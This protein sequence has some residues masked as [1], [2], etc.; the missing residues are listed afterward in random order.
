M[1]RCPHT[2]FSTELRGGT[3]LVRARLQDLLTAPRR[4]GTL[5]ALLTLLCVATLGSMVACGPDAPAPGPKEPA[6][7]AEVIPTSVSDYVRDRAGEDGVYQFLSSAGSYDHILK[8]GTLELYQAQLGTRDFDPDTTTLAGGMSID[9]NG[10]LFD[11]WTTLFLFQHVEE[12]YV[13]LATAKSSSAGPSSRRPTP[14]SPPSSPPPPPKE[15][16]GWTTAG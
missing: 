4:R 5:P 15:S 9:E 3:R 14:P 12:D 7:T 6:A 2:W 11:G 8:E 13:P 10:Y 1:D 16:H